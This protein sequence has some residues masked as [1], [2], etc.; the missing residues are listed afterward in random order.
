MFRRIKNIIALAGGAF[1]IW[2][3]YLIIKGFFVTIKQDIVRDEWPR[4]IIGSWKNCKEGVCFNLQFNADHTCK[5]IL[6]E[7]KDT[8]TILG[9]Y[10]WEAGIHYVAQKKARNTQYE[11]ENEI[12]RVTLDEPDSNNRYTNYKYTIQSIKKDEMELTFSNEGGTRKFIKY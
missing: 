7:N 5:I 11:K 8:S 3:F 4:K 10:K 12:V 6:I 1:F 2:F 9:T